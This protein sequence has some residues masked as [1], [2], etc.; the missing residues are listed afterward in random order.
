MFPF[1]PLEILGS[2]YPQQSGN[3]V[4]RRAV[5]QQHAP[6]EGLGCNASAAD[7]MSHVMLTVAKG[8]LA[9]LPR[10]PPVHRGKADKKSLGRKF[11]HQ[12]IKAFLRPLRSQLQRM[13]LGRIVIKTGEWRK[14]WDLVNE[15]IAFGRMQVAARRV[16]SKRPAQLTGLLPCRN[17]QRI[18]KKARKRTDG[19]RSDNDWPTAI[20]VFVE[21]GEGRIVRSQQR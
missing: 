17:G 15:Q 21:R 1:R 8:S 20:Q 11:L 5:Q 4:I 19:N 10:F 18:F 9:V 16:R 13:L 7:R 2:I 6:T 14:A 12:R 3:R